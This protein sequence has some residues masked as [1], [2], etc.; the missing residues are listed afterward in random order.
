MMNLKNIMRNFS[1]SNF[2]VELILILIACLL[3]FPVIYM[4]TNSFFSGAEIISNYSGVLEGNNTATI[5]SLIPKEATLDGYINIFIMGP[6]YLGKFWS[7]MMLCVSIVTGQ[8][9]ISCLTGYGFAKFKFPLKNVFFYLIIMLMLM[10]VQVLMV[11]QYSVLDSMG[12]IGSYAS[13]ILPGIFGAFGLFLIT[14]V[15]SYI[16]NDVIEAAKIDGANHMQILLRIVI[17]YSKMGI[18]SLV[19]LSFIDNWN[20]VEQPIVFLRESYQYPLSVF[21]SNINLQKL[22]LAFVCGV[23]AIIPSLLLYLFLKDALIKGIEYSNLK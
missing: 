15:F 19:I 9:V 5:L 17:P 13:L 18:A 11:P 14:Q 1:L 23:L 2:V 3:L 7:S 12:L 21:L 4:F 20:M 10:P 6:S 22:D 16:P 8:V